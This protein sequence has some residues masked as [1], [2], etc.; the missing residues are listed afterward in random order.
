MAT[1][2][3]VMISIKGSSNNKEYF[4]IHNTPRRK[5][6]T[7]GCVF[8][9]FSVNSNKLGEDSSNLK[10]EFYEIKKTVPKLLGELEISLIGLYNN[11]NKK[12]SIFRNAFVVGKLRAILTKDDHNNFLNYI[13]DGYCLKTIV[14]VD[15]CAQGRQAQFDDDLRSPDTLALYKKALLDIGTLL[16]YYDD[17]FRTVGL[18]FGANLPPYFNVVSHCFALNGNYFHPE[19][20]SLELLEKAI[21]NT[22]SQ[23]QLHGPKII[24]DVIKYASELATHFKKTNPKYAIKSD[25]DS[26]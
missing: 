25:T 19:V 13:H 14:A 26:I 24:S 10:F 4:M 18:G 9:E 5:N 11:N 16:K 15:F 1:R 17:D 23:V 7:K 8:P 12:I 21:E 2:N 22:L 3:Q 6:T 20:G